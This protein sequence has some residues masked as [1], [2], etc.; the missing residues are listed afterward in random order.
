MSEQ[1]RNG[2]REEGGERE[3]LKRKRIHSRT[4]RLRYS[5]SSFVNRKRRQ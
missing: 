1:E 3:V 4:T 2:E 5:K